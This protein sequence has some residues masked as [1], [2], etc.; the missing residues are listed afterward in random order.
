MGE[1]ALGD[2]P[3][4]PTLD[5]GVLLQQSRR[6][7]FIDPLAFHQDPTGLLHPGVMLHGKR[8]IPGMAAERC[9]AWTWAT[10]R[11]APSGPRSCAR[12]R[13]AGWPGCSWISP[14]P[15]PASRPP[16][17][18]SWA[19]ASWQRCRVHFLRN[20]L[21]RVPKGSAEMVAAAIRTIFAQPT[22]AEVV[23]QVDKVAAMLAPKVPSG[24]H[25]AG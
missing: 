6:H 8:E 13:P 15:T 21:A 4:R 22:G 16:S 20:V 24:R 3:Q 18:R 2:G 11:T 5:L 17:P 25:D 12:S 9:S 10:A 1:D 7:C 23:E 14:T 19:G